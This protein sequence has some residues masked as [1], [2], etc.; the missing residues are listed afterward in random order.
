[1]DKFD[2]DG[3]VLGDGYLLDDFDFECVGG[4]GDGASG[5][6]GVVYRDALVKCVGGRFSVKS[7][8]RHLFGA[9]MVSDSDGGIE[10]MWFGDMF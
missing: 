9:W 7:G 5:G 3:R 8:L 10:A 6:L 4:A 2:G 1:L